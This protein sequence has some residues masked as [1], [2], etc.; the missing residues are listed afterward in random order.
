MPTTLRSGSPPPA[1]AASRP[2]SRGRWPPGSGRSTGTARYSLEQALEPGIEVA[3]R[4]FRIDQTFFDQIEINVDFFDDI[5]STAA[6]YL[7]PDGT[8]RNVGTKLRNP[9]MA[10]A[11][12][13]IAE[14]GAKG[15]YR[16]RIAGAIADAAQ[17]P[18]TAADADNVWRPGLIT[19]A[20][21]QVLRARVGRKPTRVGYRGYDVWGMGPP[22]E[23]RLDRRR[24]AQHP[25]GLLAARRPT[26]PRHYT[27]SSRPRDTRS[28]T[29]TPTSPIRPSSTCRSRACSPTRFAAERRALITDQ[30]ADAG[31]VAAGDPR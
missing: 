4:G 27:V 20:R 25:R 11:Y 7:D 22:V 26:A 18:P 9:D 16:G 15:F 10:R 12:R 8:P 29:A 23:R 21:P 13:R 14:R 28:P 2:G 31:P 19:E 24:G 30:A 17:D 3:R 5:P 6:I 1:T